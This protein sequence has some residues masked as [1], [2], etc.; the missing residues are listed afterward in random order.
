MVHKICETAY[1]IP[2]L[3]KMR[4]SHKTKTYKNGQIIIII[5][6]IMKIKLVFKNTILFLL[7]IY[8]I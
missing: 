4:I 6:L 5:G 8:A 1:Y 2:R 3:N 7:G